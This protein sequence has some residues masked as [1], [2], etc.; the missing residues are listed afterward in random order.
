MRSTAHRSLIAGTI[1]AL[2]TTLP[3]G[4]AHA[5]IDPSPDFQQA[6]LPDQFTI[7]KVGSRGIEVHN[8]KKRLRDLGFTPGNLSF[9]Y[10][11][12]LRMTVWAFQKA[13]GLRPVDRIDLPTW[14]ALLRPRRIRPLVG[15]GGPERTEIDLRRRLLTVWKGG[16]PVLVTHIST[17]ARRSYCEKGHCGFADTP[18]GD[19]W[20]GAR[21]PGWSTGILGS[22]FYS[23]YFNGGIAVHGSTL[24]PRF[25]ASHG[26]VRVPLHNAV[27]IYRLLQPGDPVY[28]R[29]PEVRAERRPEAHPERRRRIPR[30]RPPETPRDSPGHSSPSHSSGSSAGRK[31]HR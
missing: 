29:R 1:F 12:A 16:K 27:P 20:V 7:L 21:V 22:M 6:P 26:C 2:A 10:D 30:A 3:A 17:G 28:V 5:A 31:N 15:Y 8:V 23:V 14:Q 9:T 4:V 25:P 19:Y 24:V 18:V 13:N 11:S